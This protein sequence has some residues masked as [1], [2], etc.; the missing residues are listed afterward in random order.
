M[1]IRVCLRLPSPM[2]SLYSG[3][4]L[5]QFTGYFPEGFSIRPTVVRTLFAASAPR[6]LMD[7][8]TINLEE[9]TELQIP[10]RSGS[11]VN[12]PGGGGAV[13]EVT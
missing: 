1:Q 11:N 7:Q 2:H 13:E 9:E 12:P 8:C 10:L 5:N 4:K 6:S 3:I